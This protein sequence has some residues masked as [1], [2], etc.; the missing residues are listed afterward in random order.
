MWVLFYDDDDVVE[1]KYKVIFVKGSP[2]KIL[3]FCERPPSHS[4]NPNV[5]S[6]KPALPSAFAKYWLDN[7]ALTATRGMR[8]LGLAFKVVP[9]D[10]EFDGHLPQYCGFT[11]TSLL[12][13]YAYHSLSSLL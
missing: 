10:F 11:L 3:S 6:N 8:V 9:L 13:T 1:G 5:M 2:E 7:A 12:G 4:N